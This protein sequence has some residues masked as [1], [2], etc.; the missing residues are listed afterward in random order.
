MKRG[1][2]ETA[3]R[4]IPITLVSAGTSDPIASVRVETWCERDALNSR[5]FL[6]QERGI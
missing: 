5:V 2:R 6:S 4:H 3:F 1:D